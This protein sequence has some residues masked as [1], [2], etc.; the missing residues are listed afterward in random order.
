MPLPPLAELIDLAQVQA[1]IEA[2]YKAAG[3]PCGLIDARDGAVLAGIGWQDICT[4]FH[5]AHP[6]TAALC[7]ESDTAIT[8]RVAE[9]QAFANK[10]PSGLWDI[11][12]PVLVRGEH[13]G[14][15][16]LGQFFYEDEAPDREFFSRQA[17]RYGFD[18]EAY[19]E[20]L[21]RVPDFSRDRIERILTYNKAFAGFLGSLAEGSLALR[22]EALRLR[23]AELQ[24][25]QRAAMVQT[26]MDAIPSPIFAKGA[27]LR[28]SA[29]NEAMA[30]LI[31]LPRE[32]VLGRTVFEIYPRNL[33]EVYDRMDRRLLAQGGV[34]EYE[35][36]MQRA[37]G[38]VREMLFR[39]A[40]FED[41][42]GMPAGMVGVMTD[43]TGRK[44]A[45][46]ALRESEERYRELFDKA[47]FG[48]LVVESASFRVVEANPMAQRML[49]RTPEELVGLTGQDVIHPDDLAKNGLAENLQR[50]RDGESVVLERRFRRSDGAWL[51]MEVRLAQM[52]AT[53]HMVMFTDIT[54][55]KAAQRALEQSEAFTRA[56]ME[57]LPIGIAVNSVDPQVRFEYMNEN[58][59]RLYR[60]TREALAG[61]DS[62]WDAVYEDPETRQRLRERVLADCASG[63]PARMHWDDVPI[64]R[65]GEPTTYVTARNVPLPERGLMISTVWDVTKRKLAEEELER[66]RR[67]LVEF[68]ALIQAM[69]DNM[70]DML[71]AKDLEGRFLFA[72]PAI[73][74]GLLCSDDEEVLGRTDLYFAQR[75]RALGQRHTFGE[76]CLNSDEIVLAQN[77]PGR[78]EEFGL[79]RGKH[80]VLDVQKSPL[81]DS[82]GRCI[83][84]VGTARDITA[85]MAAEEA[86]RESEE[87]FRR[88][89]ETSSEG[90]CE[91]DQESTIRYVNPR[92]A[93]LLGAAPED[94]PGRPMFDFMFPEDVEPHKERMGQRR[95]GQ[96][97]VYELRL[98]HADGSELWTLVSASPVRGQDGSFLGSFGMYTDIT[99]RKRA[100]QTLNFL[101]HCGCDSSGEEF[102]RSLSRY[103]GETLAMDFVCI[104][105]LE[106]DGLHAQTVA[107]YFDGHFEDNVRYALADTP[108]GEL[109]ERKV[110]FHPEGVRARFPKDQVLQDMKAESYAGTILWDHKGVAPIGLIAVI[111]R[112]K[113]KDRA[114]VESLLRLV[115]VRAAAELERLDAQSQLIKSK[116]QAESAAKAKSEFLA[117][118]S[119]E[120]RTPLNGI[121]GMLQL[122]QGGVGPAEQ[123]EFTGM[124]LGAGRRL[125]SLLND[126]LDISRLDAGRGVLRTEPFRLRDM[127]AAVAETFRLTCENKRLELAFDLEPGIPERLVGDEARIRQVLFNLVGNAVKFTMQGGIRVSAWVR[128]NQARPGRAHVYFAVADT[129]IGIP[130]DKIA[131]V[132]ERFTQSDGSQ[133][134]RFEGA[135]LGLA[136]VQ[137]IVNLMGGGIAVESE[138]GEGTTMVVHLPLGL[139]PEDAAVCEAPPEAE[140][141]APAALRILVAEDE[142]IGQLAIQLMLQ[143]L[144]HSVYCVGNGLQAVEAAAGQDFDCILMDVQMPE[145]DGVA[146]TRRI[147]A[148]PDP[149]GQVRIVAL[150]A[151][152]MDGD[153]ERFLAD[154]MNDYLSKPVQMAELVRALDRVRRPDPC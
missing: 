144:G 83:G 116:E 71:W 125:L 82:E 29:C 111:G 95:Q 7:R 55:R 119:H 25:S 23:R 30:R 9:G 107:V 57:N 53:R 97:G 84:T 43:I 134:R 88:M 15:L 63:D 36:Q 77:A 121:L 151:Y 2:H 22:E 146:A 47:A 5:R 26:L 12:I 76:L 34:Q 110:C 103:L 148:L 8:G 87:R 137:R 80:L 66:S 64:T 139:A 141:P 115:G 136:I 92:M 98:R 32:A 27:D 20:A 120:I 41:E 6:E 138:P 40:V 118:M 13:L 45:E 104:D 132:F 46:E 112:R 117:N 69:T 147:R 54:E 153:R 70:I 11:G 10:C 140:S 93:E 79:V 133:T 48:I 145:L 73:R 17:E 35:G 1:M 39:K 51:P 81:Y 14:T 59:L 94:M 105:R 24:A 4:R 122:L 101:V 72:N 37:D 124:A 131:S 60:T 68:R 3:V 78:F 19:L 62:F 58:F 28:Y 106:G 21:A 42:A 154:G 149:R 52:G 89:V 129:G 91:L 18:R 102:F 143:R 49:D 109:L 44:A 126:V 128:P 100:E 31:G 135:G 56:V 61:A 67:E 114:Q 90:V 113:A 50:M 142:P 16:F 108:C 38:E 152:A 150:T 85:R 96:G 86:L 75:Q 33:A 123:A 99:E 127:F 74:Q 65:A 130:A